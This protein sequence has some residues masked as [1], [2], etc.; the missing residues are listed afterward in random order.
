MLRDA[1]SDVVEAFTRPFI[2]SF[3]VFSLA[4]SWLYSALTWDA[5]VG[6]VATVI[7]P[8]VPAVVGGFAAAWRIVHLSIIKIRKARLETRKAEDEARVA[9]ASAII[10]EEKSAIEIERLRHEARIA[11]EDHEREILRRREAEDKLTY[12]GQIAELQSKVSTV[13]ARLESKD[14]ELQEMAMDL[15]VRSG[16]LIAKTTSTPGTGGEDRP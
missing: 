10:A 5:R 14:R 9:A 1:M 13:E 12:S 7:L 11:R 4:W 2:M 8:L 15:L 16:D 3:T 6:A